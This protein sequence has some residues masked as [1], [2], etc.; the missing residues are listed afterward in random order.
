MML[1]VALVFAVATI[2]TT[3]FGGGGDDDTA[4]KPI[5]ASPP[6]SG[7][8]PS[9][10]PSVEKSLPAPPQLVRLIVPS[11][12][13]DAPIVAMSTGRDGAMASPRSPFVV[14]W[15]DFSALPGE[16]SNVVI[17][18]HAEYPNHGPAVFHGLAFIRAGDELQLLLPDGTMARYTITS[19]ETYDAATAPVEAIAG[20]TEAEVITLIATSAP[21]DATKRIVV[22]GDRVVE[23]AAR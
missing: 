22:R 9:Q 2:V 6:A 4:F 20:P 3:F 16:G 1:G 23:A 17:A 13:I 8:L 18:G 14:A 5:D 15:Y 12:Q 10:L 21:D 11:L 19:A 7:V